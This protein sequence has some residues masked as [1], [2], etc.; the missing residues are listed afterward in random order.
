MDDKAVTIS[1]EAPRQADASP[2]GALFKDEPLKNIDD[3]FAEIDELTESWNNRLSVNNTRFAERYMKGDLWIAVEVVFSEDSAKKFVACFQ[4]CSEFWIG[5]RFVFSPAGKAVQG[6]CR[7]DD[8]SV[9]ILDG[10]FVQEPKGIPFPSSVRLYTSD[11]FFSGAPGK[12][13]EGFCALIRK[14]INVGAYWEI[15]FLQ[16]AV[17][18][19]TSTENEARCEAIK[20]R[21]RI[22]NDITDAAAPMI[23]NRFGLVDTENL[24][25]GFRVFIDNDT[26]GLSIV[27]GANLRAEFCKV[28][29]G[30]IDLNS[31][32]VQ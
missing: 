26:I 12:A 18:S 22:M 1:Y 23:G 21:P 20:R 17:G 31:T 24:D 32:A 16:R 5:E 10:K 27:E 30:P 15:G 11:E 29:V 6:G 14:A 19:M 2:I 28:F 4:G 25:C 8:S 7:W 13:E 9:F 3:A